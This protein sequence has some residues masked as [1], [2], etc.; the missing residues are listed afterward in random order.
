MGGRGH[1]YISTTSFLQFL[2]HICSVLHLSYFV[3][4]SHAQFCTIEVTHTVDFFPDL[5][6]HSRTQFHLSWSLESTVPQDTS[7]ARDPD[8]LPVSLEYSE[9]GVPRR[10]HALAT[11]LISDVAVRPLLLPNGGVDMP[12]RIDLTGLGVLA[13]HSSKG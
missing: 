3:L 12:S 11:T 5:V 1:K 10:F 8:R 7:R 13:S 6:N 9:L 2:K 4:M